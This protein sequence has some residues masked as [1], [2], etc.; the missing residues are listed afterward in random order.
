MSETQLASFSDAQVA[1]LNLSLI[2]SDQAAAMATAG[3]LDNLSAA[4]VQSLRAEAIDSVPAGVIDNLT[5][6]QVANLSLQQV[7]ALTGAQLQALATAGLLDDLAHPLTNVQLTSASP[8]GLGLTTLGDNSGQTGIEAGLFNEII[9]T[10]SLVTGTDAT[11]T[12]NKLSNIASVVDRVAAA[13]A[14]QA[15]NPALTENDF[16]AIGITG[17]TANNL[18]AVLAEIAASADNGSGIASLSAIRTLIAPDAITNLSLSEG[19]I[20]ESNADR[21]TNAASLTFSGTARQGASVSVWV[22]ADGDNVVDS[23]ETQTVTADANTGVFTAIATA[24]VANGLVRATATQTDGTGTSPVSQTLVIERDIAAP[25]LQSATVNGDRLV[26]AYSH[27]LDATNL[28]DLAKYTVLLQDGSLTPPTIALTGTPVVNGN[29][30]VLTLATPVNAG[31]VITFSYTDADTTDNAS[32]VLQ[33][34]AGNDV[35]DLTNQTVVN[36][37]GDTRTLAAPTISLAG[38]VSDSLNATEAADGTTVVVNLSGTGAQANDTVQLRWA[39]AGGGTETVSLSL[40]S[41]HITNGSATVTVPNAAILT[42][43]DGTVNV[44]ARLVKAGFDATSNGAAS[45]YSAAQSLT[46]ATNVEP[47]TVQLDLAKEDDSGASFT[48]NITY[49]MTNLTIGGQVSANASVSL[50][51]DVNNNGVNDA[52]ESLGSVVADHLGVFHRDVSLTGRKAFGENTVNG[53]HNLRAV[54]TD[55]QGNQSVSAAL[56]VEIATL[57]YVAPLVVLSTAD[58]TG[59]QGDSKTSATTGVSLTGTSSAQS[60]VRAFKDLNANNQFD[61]GTDTDFG[62]SSTDLQGNFNLDLPGTWTSGKHTVSFQK[63]ESVAS[64]AA[65]STSQFTFEVDA[66]SPTLEAAVGADTTVNLLFNEVLDASTAPLAGAF[67]LAGNTVTGVAIS[68]NQVTL[69]LQTALTGN[70]S[71][72]YTAPSS[73]NAVLQD[74][75]GNDVVSA[76]FNVVADAVAPI[77]DKVISTSAD[78]NYRVG[79]PVTL[80]VVFDKTVSV[81]T[82]GGTPTLTLSNGAVAD[83]VGVAGNRMVFQYKVQAGDTNSADLNIGAG[84]LALNGASIQSVAGVA[85]DLS[86]LTSADVKAV[87]G[88]TSAVLAVNGT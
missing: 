60:N 58:D 64:G 4:Q 74:E 7:Q 80:Q 46:V 79:D 1:L 32:G 6:T 44:D 62:I 40:T 78:G 82:S 53:I 72:T 68:G 50:F 39:K 49:Q 87:D 85:A 37:T 24:T 8:A 73:G 63:V 33:D 70:T 28:P 55:T 59:V 84:G 83:F 77:F 61:V 12:A 2:N 35:G 15:V 17:V 36:N 41:T 48:D 45:A 20:G 18:S 21:L 11:D 31:Q 25:T 71:V 16:A 13:A 67:T 56:A 3:N 69:T 51:D 9:N 26:L 34:L 88:S 54:I 57:G 65:N 47:T 5:S 30:L 76:T 22:D 66:N 42:V 23:G 81:D 27:P 52:G 14:G 43:G 29:T 10:Q 19:D 86:G 75:A 38:E